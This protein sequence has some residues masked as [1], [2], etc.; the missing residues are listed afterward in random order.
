MTST[1]DCKTADVCHCGNVFYTN[2]TTLKDLFFGH[3]IHKSS[4]SGDWKHEVLFGNAR[5]EK[6]PIADYFNDSDTETKIGDSAERRGRRSNDNSED[7]TMDDS[8]DTNNT[9]KR[10]PAE[11]RGRSASREKTKPKKS[12]SRSSG[13]KRDGIRSRNIFE[14]IEAFS[15]IDTEMANMDIVRCSLSSIAL[16]F[17]HSLFLFRVI[18]NLLVLSPHT[19]R[20]LSK[21]V[22]DLASFINVIKL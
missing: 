5:P 14:E 10:R 1:S 9:K 18:L 12:R 17:S 20:C 6:L 22:T 7:V 8:T 2:F 13:R 19:N 16:F 15:E 4:P 11:R 21:Y 3:V